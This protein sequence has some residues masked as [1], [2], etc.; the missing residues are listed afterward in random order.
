MSQLVNLVFIFFLVIT[1]SGCQNAE[2]NLTP[3][4][5]QLVD[6]LN[7]SIETGLKDNHPD[8]ALSLA[9]QVVQLADSH[10][11]D[12]L[13]ID[14]MNQAGIVYEQMY[15]VD[16]AN[17]ILSRS[18]ELAYQLNDTNNITMIL[19]LQANTFVTAHKYRLARLK[20]K[21]VIQIN[22]LQRDEDDL[23][24]NFSTLGECYYY[25]QQ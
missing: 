11:D 24:T 18:L 4:Q 25:E 5:Q 19:Q 15:M 16:S 6:A 17:R 21:E 7:Q 9:L 14:A 2:N 20:L 23:A 10:G 13:L 1:L 8:S 3:Q 22:E 12:P